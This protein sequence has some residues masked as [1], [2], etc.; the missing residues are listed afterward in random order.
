M[1]NCVSRYSDIRGVIGNLFGEELLSRVKGIGGLDEEGEMKAFWRDSGVENL[2]FATGNIMMAR[3][4]SKFLALRACSVKFWCGVKL[5]D[6]YGT[7]IKA[8]KEGLF[9]EKYSL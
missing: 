6:R 2:W 7:E 3:P 8:K 4:L 9:G 1:I 5:T